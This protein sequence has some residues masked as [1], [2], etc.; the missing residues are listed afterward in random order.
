MLP[1]RLI[2]QP[3]V[4]VFDPVLLNFGIQRGRLNVEKLRSSCLMATGLSQG[5]L[6]QA[7]FKLLQFPEE[8][9]TLRDIQLLQSPGLVNE[10]LLP[11]QHFRFSEKR[12]R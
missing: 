3:A 1:R 9:N 11:D 10:D 2:R 12:V 7:N 8:I 4:L 6:D 5:Q